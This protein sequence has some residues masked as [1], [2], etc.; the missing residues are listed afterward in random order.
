MRE[1]LINIRK[2][3]GFSQKQVA[4]LCEVTD[5]YYCYIENGQ[6]NPSVETAK[7]IAKVL[8]FLWTNF[9][10]LNTNKTLSFKEKNKTA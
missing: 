1:W 3:K 9:F 10:D 5:A 4:D 8:D 2:S 6:R 7:K